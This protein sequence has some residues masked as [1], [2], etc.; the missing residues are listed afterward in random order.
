MF[1]YFNY[2]F[3][4]FNNIFNKKLNINYLFKK[5]IIIII[6]INISFATYLL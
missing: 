2:K 5:I 6:I 1:K 4:F 3:Y